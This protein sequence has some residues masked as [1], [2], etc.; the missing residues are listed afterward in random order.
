MA[1][2]NIPSTDIEV[3]KT[4]TSD[5][6]SK[7]KNNLDDLDSRLTQLAENNTGG[8]GMVLVENLRISKS[9]SNGY[10]SIRTI[11]AGRIAKL[12]IPGGF[13]K[14]DTS[15]SGDSS[16]SLVIDGIHTYPADAA[17][18]DLPAGTVIQIYKGGQHK[19]VSLY[20]H[21]MEYANA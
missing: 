14:V 19:A 7:I 12:T 20:I 17:T 21:I 9:L 2:I 5:L 1:Y 13:F 16:V 18:I 15:D 3:G 10:N 11:P 4:I 6:I 8:G